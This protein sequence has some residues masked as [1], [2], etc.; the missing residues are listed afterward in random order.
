MIIKSSMSEK[1]G[2]TLPPPFLVMADLFDSL[3]RGSI[4]CDAIK[5][6]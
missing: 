2:G 4:V 3:S 5:I 6:Y 1:G